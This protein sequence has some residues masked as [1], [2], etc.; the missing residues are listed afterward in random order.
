MKKILFL[1]ILILTF[2]LSAAYAA[3]PVIFYS[4]LESGPKTGGQDNKG[5]F[6]T[7]WGRNF[8]SSR[9]TSYISVGGG[10]ADNYPIWTDTKITFQLGA[11]ANSGNITVTTSEGGSNGVP[12]T[13]RNGS[14]YFVKTTGN[15][16]NN[17]SWN[18]PWRTIIQAKNSLAAGDI[19][20]IGHGVSQTSEEIYRACLDLGSSGTASNPKALVAYP[21]ATVNVGSD[22]VERGIHNYISGGGSAS[23]WVISQLNIRAAHTGIHTGYGFRIVG[24]DITTP[25]GNIASAAV[26]CGYGG[27]RLLGNEFHNCGASS[28]T[29]LYH[30]IYCN[31]HTGST[32]SDIE[33]AWNIIRDSTANRG[34]QIYSDGSGSADI[35]D[36]RI[37]NNV[38]HDVKGNGININVHSAGVFKV[39]NNIIFKAGEGPA[40]SDGTGEYAG[41]YIDG[42][43]ATIY[44]YNNTIY[45]CGYSGVSL[46]QT[47]L[48][49]IGSYYSGTCYFRNNILYST[50]AS[51]EP[52]FASGSRYPVSGQNRNLFYGNGGA[53]SFDTAAVTSEPKF[54][55]LAGADFHLQSTSPAKDAGYDTSSI[56]PRDYDGVIRPQGSACDIGAYEY[57]SGDT[58]PPPPNTAP[59]LNSIGNKSVDENV[60]LTFSISATDADGDTLTYSANNLPSGAS[61]NT[62]TR[63]FTWTPSYTQ[64]GTYNNVTFSVNDG[65]GGTDSENITII[66][67]NVNRAPVL[68]AIGNKN[69]AENST[70]SFTVSATDADGD[71][72]TY[73]ASNLPAGATFNTS[74]RVFSWTPD[75][76]Q[77]GTYSAVHFQVSDGN[78][79]D[80]EDITITVTNA[81]IA[82]VLNPIGNKSM[83]ENSDL[84]FTVSATDAD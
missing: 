17:G 23:Y 33:I 55:N 65:R 48:L 82:P 77:A 28:C 1:T 54:M 42:N 72:L 7:I 12:F 62:S 37:H 74:T 8:G 73:L 49:K 57:G 10:Q 27:L 6:V 43:S 34:I 32:N 64:A 79:S 81:N 50:G 3:A 56:A 21:G 36:V 24:N 76:G 18:T 16:A 45:D 46:S 66:V 2:S 83:A 26:E 5:A 41:V 80:S 52:Y 22:S 29:K 35:S 13:V 53:P 59:V 4:D 69:V 25:N 75:F 58:P 44:M 9:G 20:Y 68:S 84:S 19:A 11:N 60:T 71:T 61:F 15:D 47:G 40:F 30:V 14:I 38:I 63:T 51:Y 78:A 39:Y 31:N 70:L 67:N